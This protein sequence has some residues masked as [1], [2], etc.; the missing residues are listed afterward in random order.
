[1]L[2]M[3]QILNVQVPMFFK[4]IVDIL[5]VPFTPESTV[6]VIAGSVILSCKLSTDMG[7]Y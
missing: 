7:I 4:Q 1:M 6:W 3:V 5:N 2:T